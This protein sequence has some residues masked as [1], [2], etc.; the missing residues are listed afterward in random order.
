MVAVDSSDV[1][2]DVIQLDSVTVM[3]L[4]AFEYSLDVSGVDSVVA[5][6]HDVV[7]V[8]EVLVPVPLLTD[9]GIVVSVADVTPLP[10]SVDWDVIVE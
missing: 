7:V 3:P 9:V 10:N 5:V 6:I 1:N 4:D 8:S 2:S